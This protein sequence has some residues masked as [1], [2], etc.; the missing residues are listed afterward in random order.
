MRY[1]CPRDEAWQRITT[2]LHVACSTSRRA[3]Y[4]SAALC[5]ACVVVAL[6]PL[7]CAVHPLEFTE[8][9]EGDDVEEME[10][11]DDDDID[12]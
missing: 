11:G 2:H 5:L 1:A 6:V 4:D 9:E 10:L 8:A 7:G 3:A 12:F